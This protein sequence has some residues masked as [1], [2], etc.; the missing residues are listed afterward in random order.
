LASRLKGIGVYTAK[1]SKVS[2][3]FLDKY[4]DVKIIVEHEVKY[5]IDG[6]EHS[7]VEWQWTHEGAKLVVDELIAKGMVT[8][9][10]NVGFK[11]K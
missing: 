3:D 10:D 9:T 7:K 5:T 4:T 11:L 8:F 6:E 1:S 2:Q